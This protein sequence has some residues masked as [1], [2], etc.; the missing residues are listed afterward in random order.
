MTI[1]DM[2]DEWILCQKNWRYLY[3]IF[4]AD[5]IVKDMPE[6]TKMFMGVDK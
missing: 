5:D 3:N 2:V 4:K 6:E 1:S